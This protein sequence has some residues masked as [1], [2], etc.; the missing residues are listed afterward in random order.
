[1]RDRAKAVSFGIIYG[2]GPYGLSRQLGISM[3]EAKRFIGAYF[4]RYP[5]VRR[6]MD[7]TIRD[8][9][10]NG[11]VSTLMNRRRYVPG[12]KQ[13]D[14]TKRAA[15]ERVAVNAVI[16]GS[17]A[18]MI[19]VAMIRI[20]NHLRQSGSQAKLLIQIHD[21]LLLETP[22]AEKDAVREMV[23]REM[24]NALP[25]SVPVKVKWGFGK[26]WMEVA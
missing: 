7:D 4:A 15:E 6:F 17:A 23:V 12:L 25:L 2:Q 5:Q 16:Q 26:N 24:E 21:E 11:Y 8:G 18:D 13:T 9:T 19:K 20:H 3:D 14:K 1:M 22:E 10:N